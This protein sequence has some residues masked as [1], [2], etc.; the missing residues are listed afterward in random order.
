[1]S[2]LED[3]FAR[4]RAEMTIQT[5]KHPALGEA[6]PWAKARGS[7][8]AIGNFDGVHRG[9]VTLLAQARALALARDAALVVL[10]FRPHPSEYFRPG[11]PFVRLMSL[12][13]QALQLEQYGVD[14]LVALRFDEVLSKLSPEEFFAQVLV[15]M[16]QVQGVVVGQDFRFGHKR[17]GDVA[18]LEAMCQAHGAGFF[19]QPAVLDGELAISSS[20]VR[21]AL[22]RGELEEANRLLGRGLA[23][24]GEV[25]HGDA[26]GRTMGYPTANVDVGREIFLP[27]GIYATRL[28]RLAEGDEA[29]WRLACS[30][31][32]AR[33]T[34]GPGPRTFE[35]FVLDVAPGEALDLYGEQVE[36]EF[37][38]RIR[39]DRAY[40]DVSALMAQMDKDIEQ[41][42][43]RLLGW[44]RSEYAGPR[45]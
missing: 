38:S 19:A 22:E 14:A 28:R 8:V 12:E 44:A 26:R 21:E 9:H 41:A 24:R 11:A 13:Q 10:S 1:M 45:S 42:R 34:F 39:E 15:Q 35:T 3:V 2:S 25:I 7:V 18:T 29:G 27:D 5:H 30:Y 17:S 16:L 40:E 37:V 36:V 20:R 31:L 23:L 43:M 32:G 4:T 33:P 6:L